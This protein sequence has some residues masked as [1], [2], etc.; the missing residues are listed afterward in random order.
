MSIS[1]IDQRFAFDN[2]VAVDVSRKSFLIALGTE[3]GAQ[4]PA[5][6]GAQD[7]PVI[8]GP[9][10]VFVFSGFIVGNQNDVVVVDRGCGDGR[11]QIG[12]RVGEGG[13]AS[14]GEK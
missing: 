7:S 1:G 14:L 3:V 13:S 6:S 2:A 10:P 5:S 4:Q 9:D 8:Q 12:C 11:P